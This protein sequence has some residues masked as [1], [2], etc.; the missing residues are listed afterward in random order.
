MQSQQGELISHVEGKGDKVKE[1]EDG[2]AKSGVSSS[3]STL[4]VLSAGKGDRWVRKEETEGEK[5]GER[6]GC[7]GRTKGWLM[8]DT[9]QLREGKSAVSRHHHSHMDVH[10]HVS[11]FNSVLHQLEIHYYEL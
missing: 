6:W 7:R 8:N 3:V 1:R 9:T 11:H 10:V 5:R 4:R 2:K